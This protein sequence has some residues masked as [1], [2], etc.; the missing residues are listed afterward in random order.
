[1]GRI[2]VPLNHYL[3]LLFLTSPLGDLWTFKH[4]R[5]TVPRPSFS[6]VPYGVV[7]PAI[8]DRASIN[9]KQDKRYRPRKEN[10]RLVAVHHLYED[11]K[12]LTHDHSSPSWKMS[13]SFTD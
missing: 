1:M 5:I 13:F 2:L 3:L 11:V 12:I 7:I 9:G 4:L 6:P 8:K 10:W